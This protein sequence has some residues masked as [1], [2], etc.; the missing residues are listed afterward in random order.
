MDEELAE[1]LFNLFAEFGIT[2]NFDP[3]TYVYYMGRPVRGPVSEEL[4]DILYRLYELYQELV[5]D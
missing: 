5:D 1:E 3:S 2:E 4:S